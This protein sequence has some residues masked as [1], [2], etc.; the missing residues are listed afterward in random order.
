MT[1]QR[2]R[3]S[4]AS[5]WG[6]CAAYQRFTRNA[7]ETTND[8]AREG[9]CAAWVAD[10]VLTR[11]EGVV[12][13]HDLIGESHEN[14]WLVTD[15]MADDVQE[16]VDLVRSFGGEVTAE[17]TV[18]A[19]ENPLIEGTLDSSVDV[20]RDGILRILDLKYGRRIVETTTA[21][22]VIY[23]WGKFL[24]LRPGSI[25]EIHLSIYQP[26]AFHKNGIH[27]TRIL[28]PDQLRDE[29]QKLWQMA[30][31]GE[32]PD[33]LATPGPHCNDCEAAASC[34]ALAHTVYSMVS[35]VQSR[36]RRDM[37]PQELSRE[38]D[39]VDE[40]RKTINARFKAIE[41]EAE[42]RMKRESIP[43][44][45]LFAQKGNRVFTLPAVTIHLLT[46]IDPYEQKLCTPA[47]LERR[48]AD[49]ER[50]KKITKQPVTGHKIT[51]V[52]S[53]DVAEM[54]NATK[55]N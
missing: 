39:F 30:V 12:R 41:N 4:Q 25:T 54:F 47:A 2:F 22:L 24:K 23:G 50:V 46:G 31:E 32:K 18:T 8:A 33:S 1:R 44:W 29:F 14:G 42:A 16:Y 40:C 10:F 13:C 6:K 52:T 21:Q 17:E 11:A 36:E 20:K 3:P 48:G 38:L 45:G 27:R 43:G 53:D 49:P 19:S 9:T 51:R 34:E 7:P 55:G 37:T 15:Q 28:T 35:V 26:R 5:F